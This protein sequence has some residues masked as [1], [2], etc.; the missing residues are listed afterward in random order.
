MSDLTPLPPISLV[1]RDDAAFAT[2]REVAADFGKRHDDVLKRIRSVE[3]SEAFRLRNFAESSYL[4]AQNK[5]QPMVEMT[6]DGWAFLVMGF[7]GPRAARFKEAYIAAFNK[8][9]A[10]L[11]AADRVQHVEQLVHIEQRFLDMVAVSTR[12]V[13]HLEAK[14]GPHRIV[15][16]EIAAEARG[17]F[18]QGLNASDVALHLRI[19]RASAA[20]IK[21][22]GATAGQSS[23]F[24]GEPS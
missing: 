1:I 3:C 20:L 4:N 24:A 9:E 8:M 18:R 7:T 17:L 15:T 23:L 16:P 11:R 19:S 14:S 5:P 13:Q 21:R 2:S 10:T 6:R 12:Y 22:E